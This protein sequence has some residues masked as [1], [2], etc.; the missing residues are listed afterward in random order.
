MPR[1]SQNEAWRL[2]DR[3]H[4]VLFPIWSHTAVALRLT[5]ARAAHE[6]ILRPLDRA[7][8]DLG[9]LLGG[10]DHIL[11]YGQPRT[12][13]TQVRFVFDPEAQTRREFD[14]AA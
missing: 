9:R 4:E 6:R 1:I 13:G 5:Q 2:L 8:Y 3:T 12:D 11:L 10:L 14:E 7:A